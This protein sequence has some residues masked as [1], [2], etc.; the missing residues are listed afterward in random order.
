MDTRGNIYERSTVPAVARSLA[1]L[2]DK[3]TVD[4]HDTDEQLSGFL[5]VFRDEIVVPTPGPS[6]GW[7]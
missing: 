1:Q 6:S 2:I 4:A 5:Q 3:I 7:P